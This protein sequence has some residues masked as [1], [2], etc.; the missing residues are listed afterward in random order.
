[1]SNKPRVLI[2]DDQ[3]G[4]LDMLSLFFE[5]AG[6]DVTT[7]ENGHTALENINDKQPDI[8][9]LDVMM[10]DISGIDVCRQLRAK[11]QTAQMPII[12]LSA[13]G[14]LD[15]KV[16][17]FEAGADDYVTK[18]VARQ[19]LLARANALLHRAQF[20]KTPMAHVIAFVGA[21]GGVGVTTVA[22]NVAAILGANEKS[23][24]L[25][26]LQAHP[27]SMVH[28]MNLALAQDLGDLLALDASEL[29]WREV[30]R[31]IVHHS[32]GLRLL[33][34]P[35]DSA[36]YCL[37]LEHAQAIVDALMVRTEYLL[38]DLPTIAG[39]ATRYVLEQAEQIVLIT[40]PEMVSVKAA[41]AKMETL[42]NWSLTNRTRIVMLSRS[43]S[44]TMMRRD[45]I[46]TELGLPHG[47]ESV[48]AA[49][50]PSPEAFQQ[51]S[52]MG[53]PVVIGKPHILSARALAELADWL[54]KHTQD[55]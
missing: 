39:E 7:A 25:V 27:G 22:I 3:Q 28:H 45:E 11:P 12:M 8:V 46:E 13:K 50:P 17:G 52:Q 31:R 26:E 55:V 54:T 42:Q 47:G 6:F 9:I 24:T 43:P 40:E 5:R 2:V 15:D 16:S 53:I 29:N 51:A 1:M 41:K 44:A 20:T 34:A 23:V 10:P 32:S 49:I 38:L 37:T 4:V 35:Q 19:E 30:N 33:T 18:P 21:K 36:E 48:I 14:E